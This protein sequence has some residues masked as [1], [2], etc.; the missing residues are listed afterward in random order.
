MRDPSLNH[1][2]L[3]LMLPCAVLFSLCSVVDHLEIHQDNTSRWTTTSHA[4]R[5]LQ[6]T[7]APSVDADVVIDVISVGSLLRPR[8]QEAQE[9]TFGSA[10]AIRNF[11]RI[12]E[13]ND[14]DASCFS[15]LTGDQLNQVVNFC[16]KTEH[17]SYISQT[18]RDRLFKPKKHIGWM[19]AQKRPL[20]G[21]Y[22]VLQRYARKEEAI[23]DFLFI[24]DD[25]TFINMDRL[26]P[27]LIQNY[28][29]DQPHAVAGCNFDFLR[30]SGITFPYGGF[31]SYLT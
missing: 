24:I 30:D 16:A 11:V 20:D 7:S 25:D 9:R 4:A 19:C 15:D 26:V 29:V 5:K 10:T 22:H 23:P 31:G 3:F 14:T 27:D 12:T 21:M 2:R 28:P 6:G 18:L 17:Q 1:F 13:Q 8:H